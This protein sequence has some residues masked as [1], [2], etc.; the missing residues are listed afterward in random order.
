[1]CHGLGLLCTVALPGDIT[2]VTCLY[3]S[4]MPLIG[5]ILHEEAY[6]TQKRFYKPIFGVYMLIIKSNENPGILY[7][8]INTSWNNKVS[9]SYICDTGTSFWNLLLTMSKVAARICWVL[10]FV[11]LL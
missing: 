7:G 4:F 9:L 8:P 2:C 5:G 3:Q 6:R 10:D 1:M 11:W